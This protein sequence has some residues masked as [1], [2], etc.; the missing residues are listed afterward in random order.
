LQEYNDD[1][2]REEPQVYQ[3][4]LHEVQSFP[5]LFSHCSII[6]Q[7]RTPISARDT[8]AVIVD[9]SGTRMSRYAPRA[10]EPKSLMFFF[11]EPPFLVGESATSP[12]GAG[13]TQRIIS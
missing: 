6:D 3:V 4:S 10:K 12:E 7:G 11:Q 5:F 2:D 9:G 1:Q 13:Y 8:S